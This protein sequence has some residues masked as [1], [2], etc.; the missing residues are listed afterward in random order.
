VNSSRAI[1]FAHAR[2]EYR[3]QFGSGRWQE[4]VSAATDAMIE[5][6]RSETPAGNL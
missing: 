4:A 1:I 3:E 5:Q 2:A 6:L